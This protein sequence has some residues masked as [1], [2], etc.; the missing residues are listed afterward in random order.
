MWRLYKVM[1]VGTLS[2]GYK[3]WTVQKKSGRSSETVEMET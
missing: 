1:A 3:N 2:L